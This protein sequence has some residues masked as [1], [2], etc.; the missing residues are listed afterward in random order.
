MRVA[1]LLFLL[2]LAGTVSAQDYAVVVAQRSPIAVEDAAKIREFFLKKRSFDH[3]TKVI[4]VNLIGD[5]RVRIEF[6]ARV[7]RMDRAAINRYW[8]TSHFQGVSPPATQASLQSIKRF[9]Q[10]V[11]GAIGYLPKEMVDEGL[12]DIYEF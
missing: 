10:T 9:I 4:P 3:Q 2:W 7:L 1:A 6:E 5:E 11:N 8:I 12:K